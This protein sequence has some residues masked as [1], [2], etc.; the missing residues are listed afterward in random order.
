MSEMPH[1]DFVFRKNGLS[2]VNPQH[3]S[4]SWGSRLIPIEAAAMEASW[5]L[6]F[7]I[8]NTS[9]AVAPMAMVK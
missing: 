3:S 4:G 9:R 5:L 2:Y 8:T 1:R 7:N 6:L